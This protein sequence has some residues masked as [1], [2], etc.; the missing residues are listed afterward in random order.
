MKRLRTRT[1]AAVRYHGYGG[2]EVLRLEEAPRPEPGAG[3]ALVAVRAAAVNPFDCQL[4]AG[5]YRDLAPAR[6]PVIPGTEL[7]GVVE[8]VGP[9]VTDLR[10]G[11]AV[12][13]AVRGG[14]YAAYVV[15]PAAK[16]APM[17]RTLGFEEAA[18][19]P[20]GAMTA[21]Q[22]L[23]D[24]ARLDHGQAVLVHAAAGGVGT[25]AVQLA[26]WRGARVLGTASPTHR[27]Y[28]RE[29]GV[30][31]AIDYQAVPFEEIA[32][33]LDVVLDL[34]GGDTLARSWA[35]L[36]PGGI[37]VSTVEEPRAPAGKR[38]V[39]VHMK[40]SRALLVEI[41]RLIDAGLLAPHV[42]QV[43]PLAE[44]ARAHERSQGHH[45][46]GKLVLAMP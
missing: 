9:G 29:L 36:K 34:V 7:A 11:D 45:V 46:F 3:E 18:A 27:P 17:P 6:F 24:L 2:P 41:G 15:A 35:V 44:A 1:M 33:D 5:A 30:D 22:A 42:S 43:L 37:L 32:H 38:G 23:F 25:Y 10:P 28:L 4:R 20:V 19:V 13:G 14:A 21:W 8:E 12:Y 40:P 16:L 39:Q 26:R 31:V